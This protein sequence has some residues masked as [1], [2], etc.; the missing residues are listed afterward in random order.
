MRS[1][2]LAAPPAPSSPRRRGGG[3][4]AAEA[5]RLSPTLSRYIGRQFL[6]W[7]AVSLSGSP[8]SSSSNPPTARGCCGAR[9]P[10]PDATLGIVLVMRSSAAAPPPRP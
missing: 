4:R 1:N 10:E 7:G 6:I 9:H 8:S 3:L 2:L 5:I